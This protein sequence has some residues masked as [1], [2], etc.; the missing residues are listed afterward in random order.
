[1]VKERNIEE[2]WPA[3]HV[4]EMKC[5]YKIF[6]GRTVRGRSSPH[7]YFD[8][9]QPVVLKFTDNNY[10]FPLNTTILLCSVTNATRADHFQALIYNI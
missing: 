2:A 10:K 1:M 4:Y 3:E 6:L 7:T 5:G 9:T 8:R